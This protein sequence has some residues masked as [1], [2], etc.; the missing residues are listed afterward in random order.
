MSEQEEYKM[1]L[2]TFINEVT[3]ISK[4]QV[5]NDAY[6]YLSLTFPLRNSFESYINY[7]TCLLHGI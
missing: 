2:L 1:K 6:S 3:I 4:Y 7:C 5:F